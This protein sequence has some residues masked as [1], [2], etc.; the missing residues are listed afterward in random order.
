MTRMARIR[1]KLE[2]ISYCHSERSEAATQRTQLREARVSI[3]DQV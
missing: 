3:S 2:A 1:M